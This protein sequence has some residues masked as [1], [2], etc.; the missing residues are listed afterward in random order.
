[1]ETIEK[2]EAKDFFKCTLGSLELIVVSDGE[3]DLDPIQP[4][5]AP[6]RDPDEIIEFLE[7]RGHLPHKLVFE[8]NVL[9][10]KNS[11]HTVLIDAGSGKTSGPTVGKIVKHL[12]AAGIEKEDITEIVLSHAHH[13]HIGGIMDENGAFTFPNAKIFIAKAENDFWLSEKPDFSKGSDNQMAEFQSAFAKR[14]IIFAQPRLHF[15]EDNDEL[16]GFLKLNLAPGHTPGHT[17]ITIFSEGEELV[18]FA[19]VF[20]HVIL[21]GR[22]EWGNQIDVD[23][24][25][26]VKARQ[27]MGAHLAESKKFT[28][29]DHLPFP[30]LGFIEKRDNTFHWVAK[31]I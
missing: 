6:D 12:S 26:A 27:D 7:G 1:M 10:V 16:F 23:F 22:P 29:G 21:L 8:G 3:F 11:E 17:V 5:F 14:H 25:Q 19:D 31:E 13:D 24:H 28:F 2:I 18:H 15:F 9:L 20:Q 4:L 30:G